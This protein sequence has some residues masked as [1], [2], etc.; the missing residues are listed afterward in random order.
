[1]ILNK[2][3]S[4]LATFIACVLV[5]LSTYAFV[6]MAIHK[7]RTPVSRDSSS[8]VDCPTSLDMIRVKHYE[9][10]HPLLLANLQ[11][12]SNRM[13]T[14]RSELETYVSGLISSQKVD[15]VT[16]YFRSL[17][18]GEWFCT[19][20]NQTYNPASMSKIIYVLTFLKDAES[21]PS[22]LNKKIYFAKHFAGGNQQ[23]IGN[24][25][26]KE[27]KYYTIKELMTYMIQYS[28]NDA[29]LLLTQNMNINTYLQIFNDLELPTPPTDGGEY[30]ITA[31]DYSKFFRVLY[32]ASYLN[33]ENSD[34][35]LRLLT[36]ST[37]KDGICAGIDPNIKVSHKFGERVIINSAQLHEFGIVYYNDNPY[38]LGVMS[39]GHSLKELTE[40]IEHISRITFSEYQKI[41]HS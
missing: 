7:E 31:S 14:L 2:K 41:H 23:N 20:P 28:D 29:T 33:P 18:N 30:F 12:E 8:F 9:F 4:L 26:L 21:N 24:F 35:A 36:Q 25:A 34:F 37:F 39:K 11:V 16:I 22:I 19:N 13:K 5:F 40:V 27:D 15:E 32:N 1:M 6:T 38:L 10:T 3:V 17:N